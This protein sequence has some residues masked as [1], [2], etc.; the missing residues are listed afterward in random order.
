M[1]K[2]VLAL[3]LNSFCFAGLNSPLEHL[4]HNAFIKINKDLLIE[5]KVNEI[6]LGWTFGRSEEPES[7]CYLQIKANHMEDRI[8]EKGEIFKVEKVEF[9]STH[10]QDMELKIR[11][12]GMPANDHILFM[13]N[14]ETG[15]SPKIKDLNSRCEGLFNIILPPPRSYSTGRR[16]RR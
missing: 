11:L 15:Y 6:D 5:A 10:P 12:E 1:K 4:P 2:L 3:L 14:Q 8:L 16:V 9:L 7:K 13:W